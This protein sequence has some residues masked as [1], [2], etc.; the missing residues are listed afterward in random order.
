MKK[1]SLLCFFLISLPALALSPKQAQDI[2]YAKAMSNFLN[3]E[4]KKGLILLKKNLNGPFHFQTEK[5]LAEYFFEQQAFTKSFRFY[6]HILKKTYDPEVVNFIYSYGIREEFIKFIKTKIQPDARS[7]QI[8]FEVAEKYF[9]AYKMKIFPE[10][11]NKSLLELSEKYLLICEN[12]DLFKAA[13]QFTLSKIYFE[14]G[15]NIEAIKYLENSKQSY[16]E[17]PEES[18]ALGLKKEDIEILLAEAL[19]KE[20]YVDSGAIMMRSLYSRDNISGSARNYIKTFLNELNTS[21][22]NVLFVYQLRN[23]VN[24]HQL[25]R[26]DYSNF[27]NLSNK[28]ELS[29]KDALFHHRR[30]NFFFNQQLS[31]KYTVNGNFHYFNESPFDENVRGPGVDQTGL[32]LGI[33]KY[34]NDTSFYG[35]DYHFEKVS[36]RRL[37]S[38][39]AIQPVLRNVFSPSYYWLTKNSKWKIT[40]PVEFRKYLNDRSGTSFGADFNYSPILKSSWFNPTFFG[41]LGRRTEGEGISSS[42]YFNLGLSNSHFIYKDILWYSTLDFYNNSNSN[43]SLDFSQYSLSQ[44]F[45]I[46]IKGYKRLKLEVEGTYKS[47]T[48]LDTSVT[49]MEFALGASLTL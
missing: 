17:K 13:S 6:Q 49:S 24:A 41:G 31:N 8:A 38:L 18:E 5:Y 30:F 25:S 9:D 28:D 14:R 3:Q 39:A 22:F 40:L 33:K 26:E 16:D 2:R 23:K 29:E 15:Q 10:E 43:D 7:L 36:G 11:F 32:D 47:R 4:E 20:G 1:I 27:S 12:F 37:A 19:T 34:S 35:L 48:L 46:P 45:T 21:F 44:F 42:L